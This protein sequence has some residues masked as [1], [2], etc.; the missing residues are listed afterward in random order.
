[1]VNRPN[2][3]KLNLERSDFSNKSFHV[4]RTTAQNFALHLI[5]KQDFAFCFAKQYDNL[6]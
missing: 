1:M 3:T 4:A 6:P 5:K 2:M